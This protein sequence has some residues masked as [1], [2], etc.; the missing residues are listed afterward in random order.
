M[1]NEYDVVT[2]FQEIEEIL[3]ESMKRNLTRHLTEERKENMNWS[4]W[5]TEQLK[6][7]EQFKKQNKKLFKSYFSTI[8]SGLKDMIK[9]SFESGSMQQERTILQQL[10]NGTLK[11]SNKQINKLLHIYNTTKNQRIKKKQLAR[12]EKLRSQSNGTFFKIND[13]KLK[14]LIKASTAD[15]KKAEQSILRFAQ[16]QYRSIIYKSQVFSNSGV[17]TVNQSIDMATKDFL[18]KGINSIQ[19]SNG[20]MVNVASYAE[21]AIRTANKRAYLYGEGEKRA[22]WGVH[23]V[24]IPNRGG[25]CPYC[26]KW[27]GRVLIDD[28]YSGGTSEESSQTGYP[29]LSTA[30]QAKL[31]HPGCKDGLSTYFD[32]INTKPIPPTKE[33]IQEKAQ[34]Y[35]I[36]QKQRYNERQI[37]KYKRL[38]LGSTDEE[39]IQKYH[40]KRVQW[41]KFNKE[42]C[43]KHNLKRNYNKE[44]IKF[45]NK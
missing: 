19:Y 3:I 17:G 20:A 30:M 34:N 29:L 11:S 22:E 9:K 8:N 25:G 43:E 4:A 26:V 21:M 6:G 23:T 39:N 16:D 38:E 14:A 32:G 12:L 5:Q 45:T 36:D 1:K 31:F 35:V 10:K 41:Q 33:E 7:L 15:M 18:A 2:I 37:R 13:K 27:Q 40:D 42:F 28:V 44:S 24:L